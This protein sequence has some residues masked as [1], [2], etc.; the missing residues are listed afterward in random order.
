MSRSKKD[1]ATDKIN[2]FIG[3]SLLDVSDMDILLTPEIAKIFAK[4][5][6][7]S[8]FHVGNINQG[9]EDSDLFDVIKNKKEILR[10]R[11][12]IK[13]DVDLSKSACQVDTIQTCL[14]SLKHDLVDDNGLIVNKKYKREVM[15][16]YVA[17][18][19][20]YMVKEGVCDAINTTGC[21]GYIMAFQKV[22]EVFNQFNYKTMRRL[23]YQ[24]S[25]TMTKE[26]GISYGGN[27][28]SLDSILLSNKRG[29]DREEA[30]KG[31]EAFIYDFNCLVGWVSTFAFTDRMSLEFN[32]ISSDFSD[33]DV[34]DDFDYLLGSR[35]HLHWVYKPEYKRFN[36][37]DHL[38]L[39]A[40]R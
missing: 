12:V 6:V 33:T 21:N 19:L 1:I 27:R 2:S 24:H 31:V 35:N 13:Y 40:Y 11:G 3:R 14:T 32:L 17:R 26:M 22:S 4:S 7:T 25:Q 34:E 23:K 8:N 36:I 39:T 9:N 18:H 5:Q 20:F 38:N 28:Q 15:L 16:T 29:Y 30:Q 37:G 10:G